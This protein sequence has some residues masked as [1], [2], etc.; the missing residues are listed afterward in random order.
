M[1]NIKSLLLGLVLCAFAVQSS[2]AAIRIASVSPATLPAV[3][4]TNAAEIYAITVS[5]L[6]TNGLQSIYTFYDHNAPS[7]VILNPAKTFI[8]RTNGTLIYIYA[9]VF[10]VSQTNYVSN[11]QGWQT[12]ATAASTYAPVLVWSVLVSNAPVTVYFPNPITVG[13]GL[14]ATNGV[15]TN[16]TYL[17]QYS[18]FAP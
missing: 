9:N 13:R 7:N 11:F 5:P 10:G 8:A 17:I 2:S 16:A 4:I 3:I 15:Y 14:Y 18:P 12:N 6:G 1:K